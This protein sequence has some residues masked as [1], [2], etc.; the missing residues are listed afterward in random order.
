METE[1]VFLD[2]SVNGLKEEL[3]RL[4][5]AKTETEKELGEMQQES[6]RISKSLKDLEKEEK[7]NQKLVFGFSFPL[8]P[9]PS[10]TY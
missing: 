3:K 6:A 10:E 2:K 4:E 8:S 1:K 5:K 7:K 9:S